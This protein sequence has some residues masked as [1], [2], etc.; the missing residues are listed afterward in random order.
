MIQAIAIDDELPALKVIENFCSRV[1]FIQLQQT[2]N[3]PEKALKYISKSPVDLLFLDINMPSILG[4][5]LYKSVQQKTMVIFTTAHSEYAVEGFNLNALDYLLKP[6]TFERFLQAVQKAQEQFKHQP[7]TPPLI[8]RIDYGLTKV[9]IPDI[10]FIEGLD[11]YL[12]IHLHQQ[13]PLVVR[14]T[15][16]AILE[17]LPANAFIRVHRSF[18]VPFNR[19]EQVRNK[20]ILIAGHEIPVGVSY[21]AAFFEQFRQG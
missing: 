12:K 8:F 17:K 19:I 18:I 2:F 16:K 3:Q 6:F 15:M 11:D 14:M 21:E 5:D 20:T 10:L 1:D 9:N 7:P 4:T 13:P